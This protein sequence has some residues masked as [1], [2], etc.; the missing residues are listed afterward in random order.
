MSEPKP[1]D[2][3]VASDEEIAECNPKALTMCSVCHVY[4]A[5][6][7]VEADPTSRLFL[8]RICLIRMR[9]TLKL[10]FKALPQPPKRIHPGND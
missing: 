3:S 4:A 6:V 5:N 1:F 2:Y 9:A 7:F 8:C 10:A